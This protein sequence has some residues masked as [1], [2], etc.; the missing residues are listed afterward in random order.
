MSSFLPKLIEQQTGQYL[1]QTLQKC[2]EFRVTRYSFFFNAIILT[3][4]LGSVTLILY[5]CRTQKKTPEEKQNQS[6]RDQKYIL[7]KI[8]S[9]QYQRDVVSGQKITAIPTTYE[10]LSQTI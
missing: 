5:L 8:R 9:L 7:E 2:H 10:I 4:F 3:V 1:F 6:I